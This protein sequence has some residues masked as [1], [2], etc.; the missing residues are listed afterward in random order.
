MTLMVLFFGLIML[1]ERYTNRT[2]TKAAEE[3]KFQKKQ[4]GDA[5]GFF[6]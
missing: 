1:L 6:S 4:P 2:D 3:P 5:G